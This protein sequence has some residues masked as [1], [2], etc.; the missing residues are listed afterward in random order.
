MLHNRCTL[1]FTFFKIYLF[2]TAA[3]ACLTRTHL[4]GTIPSPFLWRAGTDRDHDMVCLYEHVVQRAVIS[5][6]HQSAGQ[7]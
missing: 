7:S 4:T 2:F 6:L 1:V 5:L 3:N